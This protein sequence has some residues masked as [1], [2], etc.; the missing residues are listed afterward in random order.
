MQKNGKKMS[1]P[2]GVQTWNKNVSFA[3]TNVTYYLLFVENE[4]QKKQVC[5][6]FCVSLLFLKLFFFCHDGNG[7]GRAQLETGRAGLG[8]IF[9]ER[10][11][12]GPRLS[13]TGRAGPKKTGPCRPLAHTH[14]HKQSSLNY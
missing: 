2:D 8:L 4:M 3:W 13:W 6:L 7:A 9:L 12:A 10:Q 14:R 11:R 1:S 5:V